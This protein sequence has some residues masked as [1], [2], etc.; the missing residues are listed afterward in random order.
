[1]QVKNH[2]GVS[3]NLRKP[4]VMAM[5]LAMVTAGP[6]LLVRTAQASRITSPGTFTLKVGGEPEA[7]VVT[8][9]GT[10]AYVIYLNSSA[11]RIA[12]L[13]RRTLS[14]IHVGQDLTN[15]AVSPNGAVLY[16]TS[17][18]PE[19]GYKRSLYVFDLKTHKLI[20]DINVGGSS[21]TAV[22]SPN[23]HF[24][25]VTTNNAL[26]VI[27]TST[28]RVVGSIPL[29]NGFAAANIALSASGATAYVATN[30]SSGSNG[31]LGSQLDV[32]DLA[33][34]KVI[35]TLD[36]E[37]NINGPCGLVA[38]PTSGILY[39]STCAA[40]SD[41]VTANLGLLVFDEN[42][43]SFEA[44]IDV[45]G[46]LRGIAIAPNGKFVYA[47]G[48]SSGGVDVIDAATRKVIRHVSVSTPTVQTHF[49]RLSLG[50]YDLSISR[51]GKYLYATN[52][53]FFN[54]GTLSVIQVPP[55]R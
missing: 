41:V 15:L 4:F 12:D 2:R 30:Q 32:I 19:G 39:E 13:S 50:L 22:V 36:Q 26:K 34:R 10:F 42:T 23:G 29:T 1:M 44:N 46:G 38:S 6:L 21:S 55:V 14:T 47:A 25:Y 11:I 20:G 35:A 27:A 48:E 51:N 53:T 3:P 17:D 40:S 5:A 49:G 33:D 9:S 18:S 31:S 43:N 52:F 7:L 54:N 16:L 37:A 8:P 45:K 24:V 28:Q